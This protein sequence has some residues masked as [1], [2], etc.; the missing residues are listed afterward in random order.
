[1][2]IFTFR[3]KINLSQA[4]PNGVKGTNPTKSKV[5]NETSGKINSRK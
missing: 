5:I 1:M 3:R 2:R 4:S